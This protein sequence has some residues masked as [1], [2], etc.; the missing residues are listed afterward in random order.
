MAFPLIPF[1]AGAV[2]GGLAAF[3]Y[4]DDKVRKSIGKT[5]G[6]V[7]RKVSEGV[8]DLRRKAS[9]QEAPAEAGSEQPA[10]AAPVTKKR[11]AKKTVRKKAAAKSAAAP[12]SST[13]NASD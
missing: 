3:L 12:L 7:T 9:H 1:V 2:I 6:D 4:K 13:P 11:V 10:A 5:A 8:S